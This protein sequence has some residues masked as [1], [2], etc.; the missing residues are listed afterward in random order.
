VYTNAEQKSF[1]VEKV[2]DMT[3]RHFREYKRKIE[4]HE[5][6]FVIQLVAGRRFRN[7]FDSRPLEKYKLFNL[8]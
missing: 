2:P 5:M 8:L 7:D 3:E 4:K 1:G 6:L